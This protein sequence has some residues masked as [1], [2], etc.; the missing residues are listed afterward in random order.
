MRR[1]PLGRKI[2]VVTCYD[3][4]SARAVAASNID[5]ILVGDSVAMVMHGHAT[6]LSATTAMIALLT[7]AVARGA[8]AKFIVADG[9]SLPMAW[10]ALCAIIWRKR[11]ER[12]TIARKRQCHESMPAGNATR[13]GFGAKPRRRSTG[14]S[15]R[16]MWGISGADVYGRW[17]VGG[18]CNTCWNAVDRHV[19]QGRGEQPAII[20][21]SPLA[22]QKGTLTYRPLGVA[23]QV[24]AAILGKLGVT[25][26]D[27][28]VLYMPMVP[29]AAI[30]MLACARIGAVHS[31][32]FGGFAA[33]ELAVNDWHL[34]HRT[35]PS[36][37]EFFV[38]VILPKCKKGGSAM[39]KLLACLVCVLLLA[40]VTLAPSTA[41][42][43]V[44]VYVGGGW[45]GWGIIR[46]IITTDTTLAI[47]TTDIT[48]AIATDTTDT[49]GVTIMDTGVTIMDTG[50]TIMDTGV[51]ITPPSWTPRHHHGHHGHHHH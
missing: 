45:G 30:A 31:V 17:F 34:E 42:A 18:I 44:H 1:P 7:A 10:P 25:K 26:G 3:Y 39:K 21:V 13:R 24:L 41:S 4:S 50:V 47:A 33:S 8:P 49:G 12:N 29:E 19:M 38:W 46:V 37:R 27:R 9:R 32:V 11:P 48:R 15:Q 14:L 16:G 2:S 28:V 40:G 51:T 35:K 5:C 43:G 36:C 20:Y 6:T 22:G 23:T